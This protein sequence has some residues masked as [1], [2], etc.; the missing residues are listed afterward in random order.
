LKYHVV[1]FIALST[2][3]V[4]AGARSTPA[5]GFGLDPGDILS[6]VTAAGL[7]VVGSVMLV[8]ST[9]PF[10]TVHLS[11]TLTPTTSTLVR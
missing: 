8:P 1:V 6:N 4:G 10:T 9:N 2:V 7:S 5:S 3:S 11:P